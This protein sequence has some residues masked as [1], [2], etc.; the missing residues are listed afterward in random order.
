MQPVETIRES[1][2]IKVDFVGAGEARETV[3]RH[4]PA[5]VIDLA[6]VRRARQARSPST[7][8]PRLPRGGAPGTYGGSF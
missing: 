5:E 2:V 7:P 6:A 1:V 3:R 4:M 8:R